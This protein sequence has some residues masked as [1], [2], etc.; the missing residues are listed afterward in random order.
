MIAVPA[1][2]AAPSADAE[3]EPDQRPPAATATNGDDQQVH[4]VRPEAEE[5]E[6][7]EGDADQ[8]ARSA[9]RPTAQADPARRWPARRASRSAAPGAGTSGIAIIRCRPV[10]HR[11]ERI[12]PM[13]VGQLEDRAAVAAARA[14]QSRKSGQPVLDVGGRSGSARRACSCPLVKAQSTIQ[15]TMTTRAQCPARQRPA[16]LG[17]RRRR[18]GAPALGPDARAWQAGHRRVLLGDDDSQDVL[19]VDDADQLSVVDDPDG[20]VGGEHGPCGLADDRVGRHHRAV[21]GVVGPRRRA[22]PTSGS[23]R[24]TSARR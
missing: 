13:A 10:E 21:G 9:S 23:A 22:S 1:R 17:G 5:P 12:S 4:A 7:A 15:T 11:A 18:F 24:A 20:V 2:L 16:A 6:R 19:V 8:D 14:T 3:R